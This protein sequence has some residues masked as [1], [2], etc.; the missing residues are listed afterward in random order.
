MQTEQV[1][2]RFR[3]FT[4]SMTMKSQSFLAASERRRPMGAVLTLNHPLY[5]AWAAYSQWSET[6]P[7]QLEQSRRRSSSRTFPWRWR[8]N[9]QPRK[10][11]VSGLPESSHSYMFY[12]PFDLW[13]LATC[14]ID[15]F[16]SIAGRT[17]SKP[18]TCG[19][20]VWPLNRQSAWRDSILI[21]CR[22]A[23]IYQIGLHG[24]DFV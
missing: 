19:H 5:K 9:C 1:R 20:W 6:M 4:H 13:P 10:L 17:L 14:Q 15:H 12:S 8:Q 23:V 21:R 16:D 7:V 18:Q 2:C 3:P 22:F 24:R 11:M